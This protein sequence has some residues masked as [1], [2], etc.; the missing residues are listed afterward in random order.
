M[1]AVALPNSPIFSPS[2]FCKPSVSC[3]SSPRIHG[4]PS[5]TTPQSPSPPSTLSPPSPLS[6]RIQKQVNGVKDG[7]C[8]SVLKRKRPARLDIPFGGS[9]GFGPKMTPCGDERVDDME[10]ERDGYSVYC[11]RGRRGY[12]MEDRYSAF[13]GLNGNH[14]QALFGVFDGHGG[15]KAAEFAAK[16]LDKNIRAEVCSRK[17]EEEGIERAIRNGYLTTD[18]EFLRENHGGGTCCVT[19]LIQKGDLLVS[20]VGDCRAV[21][22]R[23]GVAEALTSDHQPSRKD[24]RDRIEAQGGYVDC[25]HGVWRI[26][27]SLAVSRGIGDRHFK[28]WVIAEP[29]TKA[30]RIKPDCEFLILASDGLW[31]KVSNQEAVDLVRPL[32]VGVEK[33]ESSSA[34]KKLAELSVRRGSMDDISVMIIQLGHFVQ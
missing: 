8:G 2:M 15:P 33:P 4:P 13:V 19:A 10:V 23:G 22:S 31:D 6:S 26:Q 25:Y 32:C 34:C 7:V 3:S 11:K 27:G 20:N 5:V 18:T 14:K 29:E 9:S 17:C 24:E 28:Q 12:A 21:L 1:C 30:L 16:N